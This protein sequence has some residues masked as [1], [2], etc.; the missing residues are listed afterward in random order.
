MVEAAVARGAEV[1][2]A[3]LMPVERVDSNTK[4]APSACA[5]AELKIDGQH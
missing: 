2:G 5:M 1:L 3:V 4:Q